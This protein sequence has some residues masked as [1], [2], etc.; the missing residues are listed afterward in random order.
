VF[1][2][3]INVKSSRKVGEKGVLQL[4]LPCFSK[5]YA[6]SRQKKFEDLIL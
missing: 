4:Y 1:K 2:A 3:K 5:K 6:C